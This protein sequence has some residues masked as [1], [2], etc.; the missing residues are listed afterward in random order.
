MGRVVGSRRGSGRP[1]GTQFPLLF[2]DRH[3][4]A[5]KVYASTPE[6]FNQRDEVILASLASAAATLSW[7]AQPLESPVRLSESL[8]AA[9]KSRE[10]IA[11]A[12]GLIMTRENLGPDAARTFLLERAFEEGR[13]VAE[14]ASEI[15]A[16][17]Q[18]RAK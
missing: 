14:V 18:N 3:L 9:L 6:A 4:G 16:D 10:V 2:Q 17:F 15:L 8:N 5:I 1:I 12:T 11:T 13:R 7:S